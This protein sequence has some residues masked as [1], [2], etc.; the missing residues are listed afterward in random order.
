MTGQV[1][2]QVYE[3][4]G[5]APPKGAEFKKLYQDSVKQ[6]LMFVKDPKRYSTSL[7]RSAQGFTSSD[8]VKYSCYFVQLLG[9]F[10]LGEMVGRGK[11][12]GYPSYGPK[13]N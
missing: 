9:C 1:L 8:V 3:K 13:T 6:T 10:A 7:L 12:V 11:V 5:L 4:E 2:K